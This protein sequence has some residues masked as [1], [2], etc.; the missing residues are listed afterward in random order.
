MFFLI[1]KKRQILRLTILEKRKDSTKIKNYSENLPDNAIEIK[2][3]I[4]HY[5]EKIFK[6][7]KEDNKENI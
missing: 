5:Y 2:R 1:N 4:R 6:K 7:Q 3:I